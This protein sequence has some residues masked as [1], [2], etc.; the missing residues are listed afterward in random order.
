MEEMQ[1]PSQEFLENVKLDYAKAVEKQQ[2]N[3][4]KKLSYEQK[5]VEK[6]ITEER[7]CMDL[8]QVTMDEV[9]SEEQEKTSDN[10]SVKDTSAEVSERQTETDGENAVEHW[11]DSTGKL[12]E[13]LKEE[14]QLLRQKISGLEKMVLSLN[15]VMQKLADSGVSTARQLNQVNEN[16]HKENQELKDGLYDSLVVPVLKDIIGMGNDM[17]L[18]INRYKKRGE[19]SV[20]DALKS[21]L[22]D[23]HAVLEMHNVQVYRPQEGEPY[24]PIMQR[25]LKTVETN[26]EQKDRTIS[27][28]RSFGYRFVKGDTKTVLAPCKVYVYK[29]N[30]ELV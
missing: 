25:I 8:G 16:L 26:E 1:E 7:Q 10:P 20:A 21:A 13:G 30:K 28:V 15:D 9:T 5:S 29:L 6:A 18:D 24:E 12:L 19:D 17:V 4:Y 27:E 11:K 14:N 22:E 3:L 23:V 2:E